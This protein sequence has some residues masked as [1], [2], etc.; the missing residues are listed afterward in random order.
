M[1]LRSTV[2]KST[3][4]HKVEIQL[5]AS[6]TRFAS[7]IPPLEKR[8][9]FA[10]S[11]NEGLSMVVLVPYQLGVHR[12][13]VCESS[14]ASIEEPTTTFLQQE[15]K[16]LQVYRRTK[17][18]ERADLHAEVAQLDQEL[19]SLVKSKGRRGDLTLSWK[20]VARAV[21]DSSESA[22]AEHRALAAQVS[23]LHQLIRALQ[24]SATIDVVTMQISPDPSFPTWSHA[25]LLSEH[26][27]QLTTKES[28]APSSKVP[29]SSPSVQTL[30]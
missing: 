15:R 7:T 24:A 30:L 17:K 22:Q 21:Q 6:P 8:H 23:A 26:S 29:T 19:Q 14:M 9:S 3:K 20:D 10:K 27:M 12:R 18:R 13:H 1:S 16:R 11:A 4:P 28:S 2:P 5:M 25:K